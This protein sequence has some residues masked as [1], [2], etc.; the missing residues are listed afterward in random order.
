MFRNAEVSGCPGNRLKEALQIQSLKNEVGNIQREKRKVETVQNAMELTEYIN[1]RTFYTVSD[2][3]YTTCKE[4]EKF[5][6]KTR[7]WSRFSEI[8]KLV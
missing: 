1:G 8:A 2:F 4:N 6:W 3:S 7:K 5:N